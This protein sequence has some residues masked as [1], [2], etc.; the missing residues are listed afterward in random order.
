MSP[1]GGYA[2][3][4]IARRRG[5]RRWYENTVERARIRMTT[6]FCAVTDREVFDVHRLRPGAPI[7]NVRNAIQ[8]P[9]RTF[10]GAKAGSA[11]VY[12][13][14]A[15]IHNKGIDRMV[16]VA[17]ALPEAEFVFHSDGSDTLET[18]GNLRWRE[19]VRGDAKW[20]ALAAAAC[21]LQLSRWEA[22]GTSII[23]AMMVGTP[24]AVSRE[25]ALAEVVAADRLGLVVQDADDPV[26]TAAELRR[27]LAGPDAARN[28]CHARDWALAET[29]PPAVA[30]RVRRVYEG[31][32]ARRPE[33]VDSAH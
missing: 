8:P 7:S 32:L 9:G 1:H 19:P 29:A 11:I 26:A 27:Y 28:A 31:A 33:K 12:L 6:A 3:Q 25:W 24:V 30:E 18:P 21:Y 14:R 13:G 15:D 17:R 10:P 2:P 4:G 16:A 20:D 5:L 23:E 22:F